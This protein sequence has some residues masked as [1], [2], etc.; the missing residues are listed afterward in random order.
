MGGI[1]LYTHTHTDTHSYNKVITL[2]AISLCAFF[3]LN[4]TLCVCVY[5]K[6]SCAHQIQFPSVIQFHSKQNITYSSAQLRERE[7]N[8]GGGAAILLS[9]GQTTK[10]LVVNMA[11]GHYISLLALVASRPTHTHTHKSQSLS[12]N[13]SSAAPSILRPRKGMKNR[14]N[15]YPTKGD[16]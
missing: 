7:N 5:K 3:L 2:P 10:G 13:S 14:R 6:G 9:P 4:S 12:P 1:L 11:N 16:S 15:G 8:G